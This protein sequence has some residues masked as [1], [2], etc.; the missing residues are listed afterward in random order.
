[1]RKV[2]VKNINIHVD[3]KCQ[4]QLQIYHLG[5]KVPNQVYIQITIG[6]KS[7][8]SDVNLS[9]QITHVNTLE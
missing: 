2:L 9:T 8:K 4:L 7:A 1:M 3:I 5:S 6:S